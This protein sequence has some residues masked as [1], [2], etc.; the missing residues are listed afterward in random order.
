MNE[1]NVLEMVDRMQQLNNLLLAQEVEFSI[2]FTKV[3]KNNTE[4]EGYVLKSS[5]YNCAPTIYKNDNW[6]NKTDEEVVEFLMS[7][8]KELSCQV[9]VSKFM[10]K[11][12]ITANV[13][14]RLVSQDNS[15]E[16]EQ[17]GIAHMKF[18]DMNILFYLR[19]DSFDDEFGSLQVTDN[20]LETADITIDDAYNCALFNIESQVEIK[21]MEEVLCD[22]FGINLEDFG[23][24]QCPMVVCTTKDKLQGAATMLCE[25]VLIDLEERIGGKVAILPSSIHEFI[26]I[27]YSQDQD[28]D[29][30]LNMVKEINTNEVSAEDKL[31][32]SVYVVKNQKIQ[33]AI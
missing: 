17:R 33:L 30:F 5:K 29:M 32:D 15:N 7:M 14:P 2:E 12:F 19:I 20:L 28:F 31:T 23:E 16:L 26:A 18:L 22:Q 3:W 6:Y 21:T 4:L 27:P 25:S 9:D 24:P 1:K 11:D 8:F 10:K 13:Y